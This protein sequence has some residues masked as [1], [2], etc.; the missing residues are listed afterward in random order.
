[1][2]RLDDA[3]ARFGHHHFRPGQREAVEAVID[4]RDV[5]LVLPTGSGK[6]LVFQLAAELTG[7]P[8]VVV[9]PLLSL[10]RDQVHALRDLG[11]AAARIDG[12]G[13][14][15]ARRR[16]V[17][18]VAEGAAR[19]AYVTP[20][21]LED[22]ALVRTLR[23]LSPTLLAVDEAHA[24]PHW[25]R[26][27]RP[28]FLGLADAAGDLG[29]PPVAALT[30]TAD[31]RT[32]E[33]IGELLGLRD[34][35]V[36][37]RGLDR[38]E[39]HLEVVRVER[40][41]DEL[42]EMGRL[43]LPGADGSPPPLDGKGIVYTRTTRAARDTA[44]WLT[45]NGVDADHYHG[46]RPARDRRRVQ[47]GFTS[48]AIRVVAA[49]NAFGLGIDEPD[50]R[51]VLHRHVPGDLE[52]YWQEAGRAG[53][54][55]QPARCTLLYRPAALAKATF[56]EGTGA[57]GRDDL[58]AVAAALRAGGPGTIAELAARGDVPAGR[59]ARVVRLLEIQGAVRRRRGRVAGA[60]GL[61]P[62]AVS[63]AGEERRA[64]YDQTR[65]VEMRGY[66]ETDG[67]RRAF[68]LTHFGEPPGDGP[69]GNCDNDARG[70]TT[71]HDDGT[72]AGLPPG[73]HVTHRT[74]G[75]GTVTRVQDGMVTVLFDD[76]GY[77]TLAGELAGE[78]MS[79]VP[80]T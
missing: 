11:I 21:Q 42:R 71:G 63:L 5:L 50:V 36:V 75:S 54:D 15:A 25:G 77:R 55:G 45:G 7:G 46:R 31:P 29:R 38:P 20:E 6:S 51:F 9:S 3:L 66:A 59:V 78:V 32:R 43:L 12:S 14:A 40:A 56:L 48:G 52:T 58:R 47:D 33:E 80:G 62:E 30:A 1:M 69:C 16:E 67:C 19:I 65:Q 76:A 28:A 74:F 34:P 61:D 22:A 53:R 4:G 44:R 17:G 37:V 73:A 39:L 26:S 13:G 57:V 35:V 2:D 68:I 70:A 23:D 41:R 79:P 60:G 10:M 64:A 49:T 24:L 72:V 27:F 8:V 18:R